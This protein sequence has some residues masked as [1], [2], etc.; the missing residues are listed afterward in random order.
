MRG[1]VVF[2]LLFALSAVVDAAFF[3]GKHLADAED[4]ISGLG[5]LS[6]SMGHR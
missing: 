3:K 2:A 4:A 5:S 1:I 6:T